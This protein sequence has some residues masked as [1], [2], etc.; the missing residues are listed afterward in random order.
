MIEIF[1]NGGRA[2]TNTQNHIFINL[3]IM[4]QLS[5]HNN[6]NSPGFVYAKPGLLTFAGIYLR[7]SA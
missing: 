4:R 2:M 3:N 6:K 7:E 5:V 1:Y